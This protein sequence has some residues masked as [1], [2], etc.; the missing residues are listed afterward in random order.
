MQSKSGQQGFF[1]RPTG[2]T[3]K[4]KEKQVDASGPSG[5]GFT[6]YLPPTCKQVNMSRKRGRGKL[7]ALDDDRP[8]DPHPHRR[9]EQGPAV[10]GQAQM[11]I[12]T[13]PLT[14]KTPSFFEGA[15]CGDPPRYRSLRERRHGCQSLGLRR[16]RGLKVH[17]A[18][19]FG[20]TWS[21]G[22]LTRFP[23]AQGGFWSPDGIRCF[24]LKHGSDL[25][26]GN[27]WHRARQGSVWRDPGNQRSGWAATVCC[28]PRRS[29]FGSPWM[30]V[31]PT[32]R[33]WLAIVK[34]TRGNWR[35]T[36]DTSR[37]AVQCVQGSARDFHK[38]RLHRLRFASGANWWLGCGVTENPC[39]PSWAWQQPGEGI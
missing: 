37:R 12:P 23:T 26:S 31:T 4:K 25:E 9:S 11:V 7:L 38:W 16:H 35:R 3:R 19:A 8:L 24:D 33:P 15:F 1:M 10:V 22:R 39:P 27:L 30:A 17:E 2:A 18:P 32:D 29:A 34:N 20:T 6:Y 5:R 13:E 14:S 28:W 36:D 21:H